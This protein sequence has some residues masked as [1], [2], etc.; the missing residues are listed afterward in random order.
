MFLLLTFYEERILISLIEFSVYTPRDKCDTNLKS[1]IAREKLPPKLL[2]R[3]FDSLQSAYL[4][5][6]VHVAYYPSEYL[7]STDE[8]YFGFDWT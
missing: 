7:Y 3:S 4:S 5:V 6:S 8:A 1:A 2:P